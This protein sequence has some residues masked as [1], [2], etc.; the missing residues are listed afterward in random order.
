MSF[1]LIH[2]SVE[3]SLRGGPG[4]A[5]AVATEGMPPGL[6]DV[7]AEMSAFE[8]DGARSSG[9]DD[10]DWGHRIVTLQGKP[11]TVLSRVERCGTDWSG[12]PNRVAH[13]VVLD[14]PE[15]PPAGP[16][17]TLANF[18]GFA[19][20]VPAI[21]WRKVGPRVPSGSLGPRVPEHWKTA[22]FDPGWAGA[23]AAALLDSGGA[24]IY[25]VLP[26]GGG[27][28]SLVEDV[29]AILPPDRRWTFTFSTR[30]QRVPSA[31]RCQ[32]RCVRAGAPGVAKLLAEPGCRKIVVTKG[33]S[34][35]EGPAAEAARAGREVMPTTRAVS[36]R[37]DPVKSSTPVH[38]APPADRSTPVAPVSRPAARP[39]K[40]V[41][42]GPDLH[43]IAAAAAA[44]TS[45][46]RRPAGGTHGL[47]R[48]P[49]SREEK[50]HIAL[51]ITLWIVVITCAVMI[52]KSRVPP[53]PN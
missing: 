34:A 44:S 19:T 49:L 17:W 46:N 10:V 28:L 1:E 45:G 3:K 18:V 15:R 35:G 26:G 40:S 21:E 31:A 53:I 39:G 51:V 43:A 12:R 5:T 47:F 23:V 11:Y 42:A 32:L 20:G 38:E 16:A 9:A 29:F 4:F 22:G 13:H 24:T 33:T 8:V 36:T 25:L 41:P 30:F 37:I 52:F 48:S 14:G 6:E 50:I 7:L 2:T 27:V